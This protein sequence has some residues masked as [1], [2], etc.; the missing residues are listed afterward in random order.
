MVHLSELIATINA[1]F[2]GEP[3]EADRM[4][5]TKHIAGKVMENPK[6]VAQARQNT[7]E[8]FALAAFDDPLID[9]ILEGLYHYQGMASQVLS[10]DAVRLV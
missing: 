7:K 2:E 8:Q 3:R 1:L 4:P 6:V 5:Y 9:A 10:N